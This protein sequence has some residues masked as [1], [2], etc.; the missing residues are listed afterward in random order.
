VVA[1]LGIT[2]YRIAFHQPVVVPG[3]QADPIGPIPP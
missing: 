1:I 3:P 2:A